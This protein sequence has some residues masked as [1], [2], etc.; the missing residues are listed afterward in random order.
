MTFAVDGGPY[1]R[2]QEK[3]SVFLYLK[4]RAMCMPCVHKVWQFSADSFLSIIAFKK[5]VQMA[6]LG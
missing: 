4:E 5:R 2:M 3:S 1:A 6:N